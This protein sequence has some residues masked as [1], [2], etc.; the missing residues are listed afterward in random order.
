[1]PKLSALLAE[2]AKADVQVGGSSVGFTYY[3]IVRDRFTEEEW[4]ALL[5]MRGREYFKTLLPRL[6]ESWDITDDDGHA[7]PVTAEAF[8]QFDVPDV[9]L[10]AFERRIFAGDLAGKVSSN[11]SHAT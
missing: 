8:D 6:I 9:L 4:E 7:I 3:V 5:A 1:M 11:N 10:S 2:R